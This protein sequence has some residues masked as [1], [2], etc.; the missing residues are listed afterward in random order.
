MVATV[1]LRRLGSRRQVT[2]F[3]HRFLT[4]RL[5]SSPFAKRDGAFE[6]F[7]LTAGAV[8]L[9]AALLELEGGGNGGCISG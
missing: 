5:V 4:M 6:E 7:A 1:R 2:L 9:R 8:L 3:T